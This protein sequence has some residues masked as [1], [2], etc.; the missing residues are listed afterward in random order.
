MN[1]DSVIVTLT[2]K[3]ETHFSHMTLWLI[4]MSRHTGFGYKWF[5][6][7]MHKIS[8]KLTLTE[9]FNLGCGIDL[10]HSNPTFSL[11]TSLLMMIYTQI[12]FGCKRHWF[13][14]NKRYS[15]NCHILIIYAPTVTLTLKIEYHFFAHDIPAHGGAPKYQVWLQKIANKHSAEWEQICV[16]SVTSLTPEDTSVLSLFW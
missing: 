4:M 5:G 16:T 8:S 15:R 9:T 11:D 3:I 7:A 13:R 10:E 2:L 6:S 12:D 14:T 1:R